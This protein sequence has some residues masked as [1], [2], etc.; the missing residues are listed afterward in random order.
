MLTIICLDRWS[1]IIMIDFW[2]KKGCVAGRDEKRI[3][4]GRRTEGWH[5]SLA[6]ITD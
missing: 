6:K 3:K 1:N 2:S 4:N 5:R